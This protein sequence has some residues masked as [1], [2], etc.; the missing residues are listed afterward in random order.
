MATY[1]VTGGSGFIG[2]N[3]IRHAL[4]EKKDVKIINV[5]NMTYAA[6]PKSLADISADNYKFYKADISDRRQL[7]VIFDENAI[8]AVVNFAAESHVDRSIEAPWIFIRTNVEGT[9]NLLE[10]SLKHKTEKFLQIPTDEVYGSLGPMGKF[11]ET[12]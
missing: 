8:D 11:T 2:S 9:L 3:F 12:T 4:N 10:L 7:S 1:L 6:H 5:D